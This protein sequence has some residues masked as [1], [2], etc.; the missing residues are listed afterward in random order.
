MPAIGW[1]TLSTGRGSSRIS[2]REVAPNQHPVLLELWPSNIPRQRTSLDKTIWRKATTASRKIRSL[3]ARWVVGETANYG[4]WCHFGPAYGRT[5]P[6][7]DPFL[8]SKPGGIGVDT[9]FVR[10]KS[11][12][13]LTTC[14]RSP[15]SS[16]MRLCS[17]RTRLHLPRAIS[18]IF[19]PLAVHA[20]KI[21]LC[22]LVQFWS[23]VTA[24][25]SVNN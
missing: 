4:P 14:H 18:G 9:G 15:I 10:L 2:F 5:M 16:L 20:I 1:W 24:R 3:E 8:G 22:S 13:S 23:Q 17:K 21:L 19:W 25:A 12:C 7:R 11:T 6:A